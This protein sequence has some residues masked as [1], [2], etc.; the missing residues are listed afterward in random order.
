MKKKLRNRLLD[1][2]IDKECMK[3][4]Q[5]ALKTKAK[6]KNEFLRSDMTAC[7]RVFSN[8]LLDNIFLFVI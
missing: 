3:L 8:F 5:I 7:F 2:N 6:L 1:L 4:Q